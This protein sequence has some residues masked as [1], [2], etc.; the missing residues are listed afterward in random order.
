MKAQNLAQF[1]KLATPG[2]RIA[3][4]ITRYHR[5]ED[6]PVFIPLRTDTLPESSIKTATSQGITIDRDGK[7][8]WYYWPKASEVDVQ[9][10]QLTQY[11]TTPCGQRVPWIVYRIITDQTN[12]TT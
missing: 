5:P 6:S 8:S 10:N 11:M 4:H 3:G 12:P 2:A 7:D 1:K 9:D